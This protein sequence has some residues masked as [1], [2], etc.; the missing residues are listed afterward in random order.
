MDWAADPGNLQISPGYLR[1]RRLNRALMDTWFREISLVDIDTLPDA[2][3]ILFTA[4]H[5]GGLIDPMLMMAA[6]PG[7]LTVAAKHTLFKVPILGMMMRIAGAKPVYRAQDVI[8]QNEGDGQRTAKNQTLIES[9]GDALSEGGRVAI[10][11]EGVT[12]LKSHPVRLRTGAARIL[13]HALQKSRAEGVAQP[14]IVPL[15]LHYS[16]QH[17]FRERVS[18]QVNQPLPIPPLPG[19]DGAPEPSEE[20]V[21]EFGDQA[22]ERAWCGAI[23]DLLKMEM[24]RCNQAQETWADR[25]LVWRARRM[26]HIHR[27]LENN[28]DLGPIP[29][30][31]AL[32]GSR[33]VRAAWQ[34]QSVNDCDRTERLESEFRAHH[35]E[36]EKLGLRSWEL[37]NRAERVSKRAFVKNSV[38][39]LWS[40][41][42]MLGIVSWGAVIGSMPPYLLTRVLTN[43]LGKDEANKAGV[44]SM[45]LLFSVVMYPL[46]WILISLPIGWFIASSDSPLQE[47][48]IPSLVLPILA[49]IPWPLVALLVLFWWPLSA[50]LH[51]KLYVR[52]SRSWRALRLGIK[53]R[54]GAIDWDGLLATHSTLA[55]QMAKIGDGLVLP[56]D[57]DW[58]NPEPGVEDWQVTRHR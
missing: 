26:I 21:K 57:E 43:H 28:A 25:E 29:Y 58:L 24:Y 51:L 41:S 16:D 52:A 45:K 4:W 1:L 32:L 37:S 15:G 30:D 6:L 34:F 49:Q 38:Y 54:S 33:R 35:Q 3:G 44:G 14:H 2:G 56:G 22:R 55:R 47:V 19:E 53:L 17:Q 39:W 27:S 5:P 48:N 11:P 12:H 10:F 23:T 7:N 9:M 13:L 18:L 46:W 40:I 20:E 36:M 42:W 31:Q 8:P 50:R